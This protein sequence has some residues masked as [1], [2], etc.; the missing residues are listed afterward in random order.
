M[1][2]A[3]RIELVGGPADGVRN[4]VEGDPPKKMPVFTALQMPA[5]LAER[6]AKGLSIDEGAVI[7]PVEH[8]YE[9]RR[10]EYGGVVMTEQG[11]ILYD[12]IDPATR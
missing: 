7:S 5:D 4:V 10:T 11:D 8:R 1:T 3:V 2:R 9:A 12:W 6:I